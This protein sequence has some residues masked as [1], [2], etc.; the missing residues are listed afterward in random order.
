MKKLFLFTL[1]LLLPLSSFASQTYSTQSIVGGSLTDSPSTTANTYL[2]LM[3][4]TWMTY[5]NRGLSRQYITSPGRF[6][7]LKVTLSAAPGD[8]KSYTL[9]LYHNGAAV[10]PSVTISG[11]SDTT[12]IDLVNSLAVSAGDYISLECSPS[13]TPAAVTLRY[14]LEF[15]PDTAGETLMLGNTIANNIADG[16]FMS[17]C[18]AAASGTEAGRR[19][20]M[21]CSGTFKN[22]YVRTATASGEG[23]SWIFTMR[24]NAT[25]QAL[26]VTCANTN[27]VVSDTANSFTVAA[28]DLVSCSIAASGAATVGKVQ[29]GVTFVPD[30]VGDFVLAYS[31]GAYLSNS[32]NNYL[33][34]N[35]LVAPNATESNVQQM[36]LA[37]TVKNMYLKLNVGPGAGKSYVFTLSKN[38]T[39]T[40]LSVTI[41]GT[42]T[43]GNASLDV[44]ISDFDLLATSV[45]P[46]LTPT[47]RIVAVSYLCNNTY[48]QT[49]I[50]RAVLH[51]AVI[52]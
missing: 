19:I 43:A 16:E 46:V 35:A 41:S 12:A 17:P 33:L 29:W 40:S 21:P 6:H 31:T 39:P 36:L 49:T 27:E 42:D 20:V 11:A 7:K 18:A 8:G 47:A 30:T 28:G 26:T 48:R 37:T 52:H 38:T 25:G 5:A 32:V 24:K 1:I 34:V 45:Q 9:S 15:I 4:V 51:K 2:P 14:A 50:R 44:P 3:G 22:L 23:T 13:G 10:S